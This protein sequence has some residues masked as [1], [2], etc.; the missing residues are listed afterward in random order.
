MGIHFPQCCRLGVQDHG[1]SRSDAWRGLL[2][3]PQMAPSLRPHVEEEARGSF[4][5]ETNPI[6]T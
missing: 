6:L 1:T 5:K 3:A 2:P 4:H